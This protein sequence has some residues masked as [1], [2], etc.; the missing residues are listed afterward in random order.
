VDSQWHYDASGH[1]LALGVSPSLT[2]PQ[3]GVELAKRLAEARD[4]FLGGDSQRE[5]QLAA[6]SA[7]LSLFASADDAIEWRQALRADI[8]ER[9]SALC[10]GARSDEALLER[11]GRVRAKQIEKMQ[12]LSDAHYD[13]KDTGSVRGVR[14]WGYSTRV[15]PDG[16]LFRGG[17]RG[18]IMATHFDGTEMTGEHFSYGPIIHPDS[19]DVGARRERQALGSTPAVGPFPGAKPFRNWAFPGGLH[20]LEDDL[21]A[22]APTEWAYGF[23]PRFLNPAAFDAAVRAEKALEEADP[24]LRDYVLATSATAPLAPQPEPATNCVTTLMG[25]L[26]NLHSVGGEALL[27][28]TDFAMLGLKPDGTAYPGRDIRPQD[29]FEHLRWK[30]HEWRLHQEAR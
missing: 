25:L 28:P 13:P 17:N 20:P 27:G 14:V 10:D 23:D 9:A 5:G 21:R 30:E 4:L 8:A 1:P 2:T 29:L 26:A 19:S 15:N 12:F 3:A 6:L 22:G 7:T 16:Y 24:R 18:H 11:V